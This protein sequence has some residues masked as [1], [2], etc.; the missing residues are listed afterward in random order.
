MS[1]A[2]SMPNSSDSIL[3]SASNI[4]LP[5]CEANINV[6][7]QNG[8][9]ESTNTQEISGPDSVT[10]DESNTTNQ[11]SR[12][13][14]TRGKSTSYEDTCEKQEFVHDE[15]VFPSPFAITQEEAL[16]ETYPLL[17]RQ[18]N[19]YHLVPPNGGND[20]SGDTTKQRINNE[21]PEHSYDGQNHVLTPRPSIRRES[22]KPPRLQKQA[23]KDRL[24]P[25]S[26]RLSH[27]HSFDSNG[28]ES[29]GSLSKHSSTECLDSMGV[30]VH[31]FLVKAL[32]GNSRDRSILL[33]LEHDMMQFVNNPDIGFMKFPEMTSYHRMLVHRV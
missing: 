19:R 3:H 23:S 16:K 30:D 12:K 10:T 7:S 5:T 20:E 2:L 33:K 4:S 24:T 1:V 27:T 15:S 17:A 32:Q 25:S 29:N 31:E 18:N 6:Q 21:S 8:R 28:G 9:L 22:D 13:R 26:G 11:T 14:L